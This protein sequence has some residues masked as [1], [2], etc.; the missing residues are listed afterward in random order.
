MRGETAA[1]VAMDTEV[2]S[3]A[4]WRG[5]ADAALMA[6]FLLIMRIASVYLTLC[7]GLPA[8]ALEFIKEKL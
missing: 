8:D 2:L 1:T 4:G 5:M 7:F 6:A 3:G